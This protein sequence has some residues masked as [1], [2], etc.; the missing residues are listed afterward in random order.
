M[1]PK[2]VDKKQRTKDIIAA[3]LEVFSQKGYG[4]TTVGQIATA[5]CLSKGTLYEY[6]PSKE[7][8]YLASVM[9]FVEDFEESVRSRLKLIDDPFLKIISY[10][11]FS[12]EFC[13]YENSASVRILND[14][15][16][17][18]ILDDGVFAKRKYLIREMM[19]GIRKILTE[20][21]LEGVSKGIFR[22]GIA[23][24]AEALATNMLA[25]IDGAS[26]HYLITENYFILPQQIA[27]WVKLTAGHILLTPDVY[28]VDELMAQTIGR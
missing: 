23:K 17:Q 24:D 11:G 26:I 28:D 7:A 8:L 15:L 16:Q 19:L 25:F 1:A 18:S 22:P 4:A 12:L 27:H 5:A 20:M 2:Y 3:A 9:V 14:I 13:R 21:L 6:F 10:I